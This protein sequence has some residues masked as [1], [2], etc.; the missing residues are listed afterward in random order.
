LYL[1]IGGKIIL[2]KIFMFRYLKMGCMNVG[3]A[4]TEKRENVILV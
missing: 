1:F 4:W 3:L 2:I